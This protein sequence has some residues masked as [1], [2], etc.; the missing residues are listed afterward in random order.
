[1][2][3]ER[4]QHERVSLLATVSLADTFK[5]C[6][7]DIVDV[8]IGG[9]AIERV[10]SCMLKDL[11]KKFTAVVSFRE[12][13]AKVKMSP[14]WFKKDATGFYSTAGFKIT[15]LF[16]VWHTFMRRTTGL[17]DTSIKNDLIDD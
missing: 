12:G 2:S 7:G 9:M 4:R 5:V 13:V 14:K 17:I 16:D 3:T 6:E 11:P 15:E 8:S 1:M 10:P